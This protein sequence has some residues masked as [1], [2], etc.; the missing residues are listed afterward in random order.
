MEENRLSDVE[1]EIFESIDSIYFDQTSDCAKV[2]IEKHFSVAVNDT[3]ERIRPSRRKLTRQLYVVSKCISHS[4][5]SNHLK[6][7]HQVADICDLGEGIQSVL[8]M[9]RDV[10]GEI[11]RAIE[12]EILPYVNIIRFVV[13]NRNLK[14][15]RKQ[16]KKLR[17]IDQLLRQ[18][19][20]NAK[21]GKYTISC[22]FFYQSSMRIKN[23][24]SIKNVQSIE[25]K[26][27][28]TKEHLR[29][30]GIMAMD[31]LI[32]TPINELNYEEYFNFVVYFNGT[33]WAEKYAELLI[34]QF[35]R[36]LV[37]TES[38]KI[39]TQYTDESGLADGMLDIYTHFYFFQEIIKKYGHILNFHV[40][41]KRSNIDSCICEKLY[42]NRDQ[43]WK[44]L[45]ERISE[46]SSFD[47]T[48]DLLLFFDYY[49]KELKLMCEKI[50][51]TNFLI[52]DA[53]MKV[54]ENGAM[55]VIRQFQLQSID[56]HLEF[57]KNETW[58]VCP[59]TQD[60]SMHKLLESQNATNLCLSK[61]FKKSDIDDFKA[62]GSTKQYHSSDLSNDA[63]VIFTNTCLNMSR[64][65]AK[66]LSFISSLSINKADVISA[67]IESMERKIS[68]YIQC[69][70]TT[71]VDKDCPAEVYNE[72]LKQYISTLAILNFENDHAL[73]T[74]DVNTFFALQPRF[75]AT[76]GLVQF[77]TDIAK[78]S[79]L[80]RPL[81]NHFSIRLKKVLRCGESLRDPVFH[82]AVIKLVNCNSIRK[83]ICKRNWSM[84]DC[85]S[86]PSH[87]FD[88]IFNGL[89]KV[90][91]F[92][93][94][95]EKVAIVPE[96]AKQTFWFHMV[97]VLNESI[98]KGFSE[99]KKCTNEGRKLMRMDFDNL[100][101]KITEIVPFQR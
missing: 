90:N 55:G 28:E 40:E 96:M 45:M 94:S 63:N 71:F 31:K 52:S 38:S 42:D 77:I 35:E 49:L 5:I 87:F 25:A 8:E 20:L 79:S 43:L 78:N 99:I 27:D 29:Q 7:E 30:I 89:R 100:M 24:S 18:A 82:S 101:F 76:E 3:L 58:F 60:C 2:E 56:E 32:V 37:Y 47:F 85:P 68:L 88:E 53:I 62:D 61:Y 72:E 4:I 75:A 39:W 23:D 66:C 13:R 54:V 19:I 46:Q 51:G 6:Y 86:Y 12:T 10:E 95:V 33:Q 64:S 26:F 65:I 11:R 36:I 74:D 81:E 69:V 70:L 97:T 14:E 21:S 9:S 84:D 44:L 15:L 67:I 1:Q 22:N 16:V 34:A 59:F 48:Y 98:L 57:I 93:Q 80:F 83:A 41:H 92:I 17:T 50:L 73:I 91:E